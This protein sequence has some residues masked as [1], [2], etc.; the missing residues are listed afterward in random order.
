MIVVAIIGILAAIAIPAYS[1]YTVRSRVT[2]G[3]SLAAAVKATVA[4]NLANDPTTVDKCRGFT[5]MGATAHVVTLTCTAASG[6]LDITMDG[7]AKNTTLKLTP[8]VVAASDAITW[9]CSTG[10]AG[11]YKYVPA[12]CRN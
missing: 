10:G 5:N 3:L 11:M 6:V 9:A 1:D 12:E 7:A 4:E 2:E 8:T